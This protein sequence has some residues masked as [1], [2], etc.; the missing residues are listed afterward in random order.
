MRDSN[1]RPLGPKPSALAIWANP[2]Q[3]FCN[4]ITLTLMFQCYRGAGG[5][6]RTA[7]TGLFRPLLYHWATPAY[8]YLYL[9]NDKKKQCKW[10]VGAVSYHTDSFYPTH[11]L[12]WVST[13]HFSTP[14][15][16]ITDLLEFS[17]FDIYINLP[18]DCKPKVVEVILPHEMDFFRQFSKHGKIIYHLFLNY[19]CPRNEAPW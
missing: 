5:Q 8:V 11:L 6:N 2:R 19:D 18:R 15:I 1:S 17:S 10:H 12:S 4:V 3:C 9:S 16:P 14:D 7:D 13:W